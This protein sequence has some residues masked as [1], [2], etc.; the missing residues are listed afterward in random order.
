MSNITCTMHDKRAVGLYGTSYVE[1][2]NFL[3]VFIEEKKKTCTNT[4]V[5]K[6]SGMEIF[7]TDK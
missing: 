4:C 2:L 1:V 7:M 6:N 5:W 3:I